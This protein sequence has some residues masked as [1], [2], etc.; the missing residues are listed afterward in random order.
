M[1]G[2][3]QS[4]SV[5]IGRRAAVPLACTAIAATGFGAGI[6]AGCGSDDKSQAPIGTTTSSQKELER[7][8]REAER[9]ARQLERALERELPSPPR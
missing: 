7:A 5:G 2:T 1:T 8:A 3:R 4:L 6:V 9:K